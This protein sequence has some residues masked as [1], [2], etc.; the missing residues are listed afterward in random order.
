MLALPDHALRKHGDE[1]M[2]EIEIKLC[3]L[4]DI[5]RWHER[6]EDLRIRAASFRSSDAK[7]A[8]LEIATSYDSLARSATHDLEILKA[9]TEK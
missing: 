1:A 3:L 7:Q 8:M 9:I 6:A 2:A 5:D 4:S